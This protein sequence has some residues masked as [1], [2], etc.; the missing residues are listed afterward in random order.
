MPTMD[1]EIYLPTNDSPE[2][3]QAALADLTKWEDL[4]GIEF[5]VVMPNPTPRP[6]NRALVETLN[7]NPRWI[8]CAQ[9]NPNDA[10]AVAQVRQAV[11]EF[12]CRMLKMMP[13]IYAAPP[14]GHAS[15]RC[16]DASDQ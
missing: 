16:S 7:G 9:V 14:C 2:Q 15:R 13:A 8:P 1:F 10:D 4:A 11:T 6:D 12:G 3:R 5:A